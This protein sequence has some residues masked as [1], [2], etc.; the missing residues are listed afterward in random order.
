L[1]KKNVRL[2]IMHAINCQEMID[3]LYDGQT[4][5]RGNII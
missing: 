5:C 4:T 1:Q 3:T 2:A